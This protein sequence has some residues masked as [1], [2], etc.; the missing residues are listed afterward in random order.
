LL[1]ERLNYNEIEPRVRAAQFLGAKYDFDPSQSADIARQQAE[2]VA[3]EIVAQS[4]Q[5][6]YNGHLI[7]DSTAI[8]LIAYLQR[9]GTDLFKPE[10]PV[11]TPAAA[12]VMEATADA[13]TPDADAGAQ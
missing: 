13:A 8:A 9:L 2:K 12:P 6:E 4:G 11:A 1:E 7:K 10:E 5:V 3:A